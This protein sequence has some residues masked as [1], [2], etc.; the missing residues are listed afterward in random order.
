MAAT[1]PVPKRSEELLGHSPKDRAIQ[2]EKLDLASIIAQVVEIPVAPNSWHNVAKLWYDSLSQSAQAVY[3]EPSDWAQA[4][5]VAESISRDLK[6][7]VVG[8]SEETGEAIFAKIPLKGSSLSAYLKSMTNLLVTEV[9]RRRAGVE[10]KRASQ[11]GPSTGLPE[12]VA[13][14][15]EHRKNIT[16]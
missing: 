8:V 13:S 2:V 1:G 9:D 4:Y 10:I 12:G 6:P 16:G 15:D 3:Y 14:L 11:D 5:L 7:Q